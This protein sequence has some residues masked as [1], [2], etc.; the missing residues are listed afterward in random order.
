MSAVI[1]LMMLAAIGL[2]FLP[3]SK[4]LNIEITVLDAKQVAPMAQVPVTEPKPKPKQE[5][6]KRQVFGASRKSIT[7]EDGEKVKTGNTVAKTPDDEKLRASDEEALPIP[8]DEYLVSAMPKIISEFRVPYPK[9]AKDKGI[10]GVVLLEI[11]IDNKGNV[12]DQKLIEGPGF[13]LNEAALEAIQHFKFEPARVQDKTV[14]VRIRYAY[15]FV[16]GQ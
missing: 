8:V 5:I 11:L 7:S 10:Q 14:A 9:L 4:E 6:K 3:K 12:R 2:S 16:L 13:G 15:R 1:H